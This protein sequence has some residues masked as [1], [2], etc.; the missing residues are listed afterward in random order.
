MSYPDFHEQGYQVIKELG[1]NREEG[2]ITWLATNTET[3]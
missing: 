1:R 2:R 3:G